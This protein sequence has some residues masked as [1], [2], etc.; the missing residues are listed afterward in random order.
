MARTGGRRRSDSSLQE[1]LGG[2]GRAQGLATGARFLIA[3]KTT[4]VPLLTDLARGIA[5]VQ[6]GLHPLRGATVHRRR[7]VSRQ[8]PTHTRRNSVSLQI[9][10]S[11]SVLFL[12]AVRGLPPSLPDRIR[13]CTTR[14]GR[15]TSGSS[16]LRRSGASSR[17]L[18]SSSPPSAPRCNCAC[19][20]EEA[21][22]VSVHVFRGGISR[23]SSDPASWNK[24]KHE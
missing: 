11:K 1:V 18:M 13:R 20:V 7:Q 21:H 4:A 12:T 24:M 22:Q 15:W 8:G 17:R 5:T 10:L 2:E 16:S 14:G 6:L 9:F 23:L 3:P 19:S